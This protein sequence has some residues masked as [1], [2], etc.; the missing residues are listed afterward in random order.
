MSFKKAEKSKNK[1]DKEKME[2][3]ER[4]PEGGPEGVQKGSRRGVQIGGSTFCTDPMEPAKLSTMLKPF[5]RRSQKSHWKENHTVATLWK[6]IRS[7]AGQT[8]FL[9]PFKENRFPLFGTSIQAGK[10]SSRS[11]TERSCVTGIDFFHKAHRLSKNFFVFFRD[12]NNG[13]FAA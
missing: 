13:R 10:R 8:F 4:G 5:L 9:V 1:R 6:P 11:I 3:P 7:R 2:G 12:L